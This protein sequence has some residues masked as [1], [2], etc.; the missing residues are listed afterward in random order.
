MAIKTPLGVVSIDADIEDIELNPEL[1]LFGCTHDLMVF[2]SR[3]EDMDGTI[4]SLWI[5]CGKEKERTLMFDIDID[6]LEEFSSSALKQI[7]IIRRSYGDPIQRQKN[8]GCKV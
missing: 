7:E 8:R 5:N 2:D 3:N 1:Y 6:E 4:F